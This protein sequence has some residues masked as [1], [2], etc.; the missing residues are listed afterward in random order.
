MLAGKDDV[1]IRYARYCSAEVFFNIKS[2]IFKCLIFR[3]GLQERVFRMEYVSNQGFT[4]SEFQKWKEEV[5]TLIGLIAL[6][7]TRN[8]GTNF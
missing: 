6:L 4:E 2:L 5:R 1:N 3:H 8:Q 7:G